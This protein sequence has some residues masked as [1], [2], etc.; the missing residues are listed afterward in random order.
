VTARVPIAALDGPLHR[1]QRWRVLV[2]C[3]AALGIVLVIEIA[4][5]LVRLANAF[6][7]DSVLRVGWAALR[8]PCAVLPCDA[9]Q[10]MNVLLLGLGWN[11]D[12][13]LTDT[14]L[15]AS[16]D[17]EARQALF[18]SVPRDLS[19]RFPDEEF[20]KINEAY[21]VGEQRQ[22]GMGGAFAADLVGGVL[23]AQ[24]TRFAVV[25]ISGL[26]AIVDDLHGVPVGIERAFTDELLPNASFDAGW[27]W[28]SGERA[29]TLM[30]ARHGGIWEGSDFARIRQQ[31]KLLLAI[32]ER[33]F[34]PTVVLNPVVVH[35]LV[36]DVIGSVRTNLRASEI[37]ALA[38]LG[39]ALD[40]NTVRR[41]S[42]AQEGVLA[43]M[44][45]QDGTYLLEPA[46]IGFEA[47]QLRMR[48]LLAGS[49]R[50]SAP[51]KDARPL[52]IVARQ[53][54]DADPPCYDGPP[55]VISRIVVH[56]DG[57]QYERTVPGSEKMRHL[58]QST[59]VRMGWLD[60]P[61]HFVIDVD[62]RV[63]EGRA[64]SWRAATNTHY[65]PSGL[66]I[67]LQGDFGKQPPSAAQLDS[68]SRLVELKARQFNVEPRDIYLHR[69]LAATRCPGAGAV[70]A[71][72]TAPWRAGHSVTVMNH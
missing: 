33:L 62:G 39:W 29:L 30:R 4:L 8:P 28:L 70:A 68:L 66:H 35:H 63:Y 57:I 37:V 49:A 14:I 41:T 27:Q 6:G 9:T 19:V 52:A 5:P 56:H 31:Q 42:L 1:R 54:W 17:A 22:A 71:L 53:E 47:I 10:R 15:F 11:L 50:T 43:E 69:E 60:V 51:A 44:R 7:R 46:G 25:D 36:G 67:A 55:Q 48:E 16:F 45:S 65:D 23:G 38:R 26:E 13:G 12:E 18:V 61:Y 21:L 34:S 3:L 64:E 24:I 72:A 20:R 32:K 2:A 59:R 58:L 40:S